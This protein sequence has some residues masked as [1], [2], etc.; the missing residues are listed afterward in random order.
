MSDF[1]NKDT[2]KTEQ[3]LY[4]LLKFAGKKA[5]KLLFKAIGIKGIAIIILILLILSVIMIFM[6]SIFYKQKIILM[7]VGLI[8]PRRM[9]MVFC[10]WAICTQQQNLCI[11][12]AIH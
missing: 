10:C 7:V 6:G 12:I 4:N 9:Y 11:Y 8:R 2:E 1:N 3:G 5:G